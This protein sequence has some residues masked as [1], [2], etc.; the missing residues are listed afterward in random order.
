MNAYLENNNNNFLTK[1]MNIFNS[2]LVSSI[3]ILIAF[4]LFLFIVSRWN[5]LNEYLRITIL[6]SLNIFIFC[7]SISSSKLKK[8]CPYIQVLIFSATIVEVLSSFSTGNYT[9]LSTLY[10][11]ICIIPIYFYTKNNIFLLAI[12]SLYSSFIA[13]EAF[14]Q[15]SFFNIDPIVHFIILTLILCITNTSIFKEKL[16]QK[17]QNLVDTFYFFIYLLVAFFMSI[18]IFDLDHEEYFL[19]VGLLNFALIALCLYFKIANFNICFYLNLVGTTALLLYS[20][21]LS[22]D[23]SLGFILSTFVYLPYIVFSSI[24]FYKKFNVSLFNDY[25]M[26]A[27]KLFF[28]FIVA[29]LFVSYFIAQF[30]FLFSFLDD[31]FFLGIVSLIA[32]FI[33]LFIYK[34]TI[35]NIIISTI[36]YNVYLIF[37]SCSLLII[38]KADFYSL[39]QDILFFIL[40]ALAALPLIFLVR[41]NYTKE[42]KTNI[43]LSATIF[44]IYTLTLTYIVKASEKLI[45]FIAI[46]HIAILLFLAI[47]FYFKN[48]IPKKRRYNIL[49]LATALFVLSSFISI[50]YE[51]YFFINL[52]SHGNGNFMLPFNDL[53]TYDSFVQFFKDRVLYFKNALSIDYLYFFLIAIFGLG[54]LLVKL[55]EK[56]NIAFNKSFLAI[57]FIITF[58]TQDISL[59]ILLVL[60]LLRPSKRLLY[61]FIFLLANKLLL[62]Y[63]ATKFNINA[64]ILV[65]LII[66]VLIFIALP[67]KNIFNHIDNQSFK[68][69]IDNTNIPLFVS[70]LLVI[71]PSILFTY[72]YFHTFK[73]S[74]I[75]YIAVEGVDPRGIFD[76]DRIE[77][78]LKINAKHKYIR[79]HGLE[80]CNVQNIANTVSSVLDSRFYI[81]LDKIKEHKY[82]YTRPY[83]YIKMGEGFKYNSMAIAK[84][85]V[86]LNGKSKIIDLLDNNCK[87]LSE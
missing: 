82:A 68:L 55:K 35:D 52:M 11:I 71:I 60:S 13:Y 79:L 21:I 42:L 33:T 24:V 80:K 18:Y 29:I 17:E 16:K 14:N 44:I 78:N 25:V 56:T 61:F 73:E 15:I 83:L 32:A 59:A 10:L 26:L 69:H 51:N 22:N 84:I 47:S 85:K 67:N 27:I 77:V 12:C 46:I 36:V 64:L 65:L 74:K 31:I 45:F 28:A 76:G 20:F 8:I 58:F 38:F 62:T 86:G 3:A 63:F 48:S 1:K 34:K 87:S 53:S 7:I 4:A 2:F 9:I 5:L 57:L 23:V 43:F 40:I 39:T 66:A 50:V 49:N 70:L 81:E 72:N 30:A 75:C 37:I 19:Y 41:N 54:A 6:I